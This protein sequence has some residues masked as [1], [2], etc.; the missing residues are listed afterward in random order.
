MS[1]VEDIYIALRVPRNCAS[2]F[3]GTLVAIYPPPMHCNDNY[4]AYSGGFIA[5]SSKKVYLPEEVHH[6]AKS[7]NQYTQSMIEY[8]FGQH[9]ITSHLW[10]A[11]V[12]N[13]SLD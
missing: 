1:V 2:N 12:L 9:Q 6:E 3:L 13:F 4:G 5:E 10:I 8:T 11:F 7:M